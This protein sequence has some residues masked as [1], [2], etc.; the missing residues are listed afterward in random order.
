MSETVTTR[1]SL[2]KVITAAC[3]LAGYASSMPETNI[4]VLGDLT[5]SHQQWR[6]GLLKKVDNFEDLLSDYYNGVEIN[7]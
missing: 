1:P 6:E 4:D 3:V 2:H 7:G 5:F